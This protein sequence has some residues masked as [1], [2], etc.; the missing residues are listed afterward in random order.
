[1][2]LELNTQ[3]IYAIYDLENW[4]N[5]Q[6]N[7]VFEISGGAGTG[8][9]TLI[10]YFIDK[11]NLKHDDVLF[12]AYTGKAAS[13]LQRLGLPATT[14]HSA[15]YK[16]KM[17]EVRDESGHL[18]F[19]ENG[20]VL[21]QPT[22]K[23]RKHLAK[24]VSL[25]VI[26]EGSMVDA[27]IAS[28]LLSFGIPIVVLGDL[29]QLPPVFGN[30]YF[31]RKPNVVLTQIMR[32]AENNPIVHLS[33]M[34]LSG[35]ELKP[36]VFGHSAVM[37]K[38]DLTEYQFKHSDIVLTGTNRLRYNINQ[39]YR[40]YIRGIKRLEYPHVGEKIVNRKN[41][42]DLK[43]GKDIYFTNGMLGVVDKVYQS[44]YNG[45]SMVLDFRPDFTKKVFHNVK[46]DYHHLYEVPGQD[47]TA[48]FNN[49]HLSR[50]EF[51]Y[52]ITVHTSQ[53]DEWGNVLYL[54]E[55]YSNDAEFRRKILYTAITRAVE[56]I[57]IVL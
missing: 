42:W 52:A 8:K 26:D 23:L 37:K 5:A 39:Y 4:W 14:I 50:I 29:N 22:F 35:K 46:F 41:Q 38:R 30:S 7:Q 34:V 1:M 31:L 55:D 6:N 12:L 16:F 27:R 13:R 2:D 44:T 32:Q 3:Q 47:S 36:G 48:T 17:E 43:V 19:K 53:G 57:T 9:S 18:I 33:Q 25:I 51:A 54:H 21:K 24:D 28:D 10:Q 49:I 15:I 40:E 56:S 11:I 20:H 45:K